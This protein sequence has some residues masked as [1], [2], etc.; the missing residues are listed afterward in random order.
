MIWNVTEKAVLD[1]LRQVKQEL[2]DGQLVVPAKYPN[3]PWAHH[4]PKGKRVFDMREWDCG[5][6]CCIGGRMQQIL[7]EQGYRYLYERSS[8]PMI[9]ALDDDRGE[10][11]N[12]LFF[13]FP[14]IC[15]PLADPGTDVVKE[16]VAAIDRFFE[17]DMNPWGTD[18][19][20][21]E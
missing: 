21:E 1:A 12:N 17:G 10:A 2:L 3:S 20:T 14:N 6:V 19:E 11:L 15:S 5:T 9:E 7:I 16:T 18:E 4:V 13:E 8:T